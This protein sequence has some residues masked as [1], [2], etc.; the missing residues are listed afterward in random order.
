MDLVS[1]SFSFTISEK[2][3]FDYAKESNDKNKIHIDEN[4]SYNSIYRHKIVHG[5]LL[6]LKII[7][8]LKLNKFLN[9]SYSIKI[10]F[11]KPK[12]NIL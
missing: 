11:N 7:N 2:E 5:C 8:Q 6:L 10:F 3:G 9:K 1:K 12:K 4:Y